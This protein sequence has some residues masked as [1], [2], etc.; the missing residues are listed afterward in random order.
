[1]S[2]CDSLGFYV[3]CEVPF[4]SR[5]AKHLSDTSYYSNLCARARATIYRH[6]NYPS[7]LIWSLGNEN[8]FPKS[9]C[10]SWRVCQATRHHALHLLS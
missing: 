3:I 5:G 7:V 2:L 1:M 9:L 6:K 4:G 10:T 8:P